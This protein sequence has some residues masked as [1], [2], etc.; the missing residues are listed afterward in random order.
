MT[1]LGSGPSIISPT[2]VIPDGRRMG[3]ACFETRLPALLSMMGVGW[4]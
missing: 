1:G 4:W 3:R 2:S